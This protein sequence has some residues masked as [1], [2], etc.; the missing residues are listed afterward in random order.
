M[1]TIFETTLEC[2]VVLSTTTNYAEEFE[3]YKS[4]NK[5]LNVMSNETREL[6]PFYYPI[7]LAST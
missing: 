4:K 5:V 1:D 3:L 2:D 7:D 6:L